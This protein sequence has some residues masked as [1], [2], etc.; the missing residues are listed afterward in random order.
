MGAIS[1][2]GNELF[3]NNA[4]VALSIDPV[5]LWMNEVEIMEYVNA[6]Y[7]TYFNRIESISEGWS[8][9]IAAIAIR[10]QHN[11]VGPILDDMRIEMDLKIQKML[12]LEGNFWQF[13]INSLGAVYDSTTSTYRIADSGFIG[14]TKLRLSRLEEQSDPFSD[15]QLQKLNWLIDNYD[16][17]NKLITDDINYVITEVMN[18]IEPRIEQMISFQIA[19]FNKRLVA[20]EGALNK[21]QFWFYD[22]LLDIWAF[23]AGGSILPIDQIKDT[24]L[25]IGE[26]F[27]DEIFEITDPLKERIEILEAGGGTGDG[28]TIFEIIRLIEIELAAIQGFSDSQERRINTMIAG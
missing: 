26:W 4:G 17:F 11:I 9:E 21:T 18:R 2:I 14:Q 6:N 19:P 28:L 22:M 15:T 13:V 12:S 23:L 5:R 1:E 24:M 25:T 10:M 3:N 16:N 8:Q 27:I 7:Y 20:V